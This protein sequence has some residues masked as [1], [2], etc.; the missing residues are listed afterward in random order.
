MTRALSSLNRSEQL[1]GVVLVVIAAIG[2]G[3]GPFFARVAYDADMRAMPILFWRFV[4]ATALSWAVVLVS[5]AGRDALRSI[6]RRRA[7]VMLGLGV[8]YIGNSG[9]YVASLETVPI[10]VVSMIV[11]I[12]PALVA[13]LSVRFLR[14]LEGRRAWIALGISTAGVLLAVGGIPEGSMPPVEGL[15]LAALSP[16]T[17]A[18]WIVLSARSTGERRGPARPAPEPAEAPDIAPAPGATSA[19]I[20]ASTLMITATT[21]TAGVWL[22]I[23]GQSVNPASVPGEAWPALI[24]FGLATA[25]AFQAFYGGL[26]R[27]GGARASLIATVEPVYTIAVATLFFGEVLTPVQLLGGILVIGGV[28]LAETGSRPGRPRPAR[29]VIESDGPTT[30]AVGAAVGEG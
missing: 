11:Y 22:L 19:A 12:Y 16:I 21:A 26:R 6:G 29:P 9:T 5:A 30:R 4:A 3:S 15:V 1:V 25:I 27:V 23:T 28:L 8:L 7:L 10:A 13:V 17:Y 24:G 18:I 2:F 20:V 14:R